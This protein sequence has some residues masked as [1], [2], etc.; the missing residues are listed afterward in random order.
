MRVLIAVGQGGIYSG[1]ANQALFQLAGLKQAGVE[2]AA[3]WGEDSEG[4]PHGFDRLKALEVPYE[5][6]PIHRRPT[7]GSLRAF[8]RILRDFNPD[9]VECIKSGAQYHALYGGLGLN[10]HALVFYRG[11]SRPMDIFQGLK[12]NLRRVDRVIANCDDLKRIMA[13]SGGIGA[14]KIDAIPGEFDPRCGDPNTVDASGLKGELG[15][16]EDLPI[17]TQ[18]GNWAPWRGQEITLGAARILKASGRDFRLLFAGRET[19]QLRPK[20][21]HLGLEDRAILSPYRRDPER[22]L[23]I[24]D[25]AVNASTGNESL[26]GSLIN[27]QAMGIPAVAT[28][29]PGSAEIVLNGVTGMVVPIGNSTALALALAHLLDLPAGDLKSIGA[30]ARRRTLEKFSSDL[31][32]RRRLECYERAIAHRSGHR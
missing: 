9:V 29:M 26:P 15:I 23:K 18:L 25:I 22:I 20:V 31:R 7:A 13:S 3:V 14:D 24:T 11:L 6:I 2:A 27:A 17:I 19:E 12:Y 21:E 28:P 5:I 32:T 8:R 10:R 16:P 4:D 1:S 30:E